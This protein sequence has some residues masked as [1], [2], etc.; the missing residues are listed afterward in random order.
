MHVSM[1][2]RVYESGCR[3]KRGE[4]AGMCYGHCSTGRKE[5]E[6]PWLMEITHLRTQQSL[7]GKSERSAAGKA[8]SL[9]KVLWPW[10]DHKGRV[11][12]RRKL[13]KKT[14][15]PT[16]L[17]YIPLSLV[18]SFPPLPSSPQMLAQPHW[19][20]AKYQRK[21]TIVKAERKEDVV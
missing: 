17:E 10:W 20:S 18:T 13:V 19:R 2:C 11:C 4:L 9:L 21:G 12:A 8:A 14:K 15:N 3:V 6:P 16:R 5:K 7:Y 1:R